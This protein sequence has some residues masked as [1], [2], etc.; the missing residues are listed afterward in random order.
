MKWIPLALLGVAA[1]AADINWTTYGGNA[2][3]WRYSELAQITGANVN[4]LVPK[5]IFQTGIAGKAESSPLIYD[6]MMYVTAPSNHAYAVDLRTG[7]AVWTYSKTP[8]KA[9]DLCCQEVNRGLAVFGDRL[10]KV[11]IEDT[12]VALD[13]ATGKMIWEKVIGDY[14][15]GYSGTLA[16]LIVKDKVLVGTAGAEFGTRGFVDAYSAASGERLW[17]FYT[18]PEA[19]AAGA[20]TWGK[21]ETLRV[22]GSTWITGTYDSELNLV[23][24][25]TGNP[26]PDMNGDVRPGDNLYT[27]SLVAIDADTG[28]AKWHFQF[29]PHD[30]HD[31]DAV[32]DPVL[33]D[34]TMGG[35]KVKAVIQ[36]NRNGYFYALDRTN[37]KFLLARPY[38]EINW[39][40]GIDAD[41]R[42]ITI[43][44]LDPSN[45]GT[46]VCPGMGGGHNW[47][48]TAYSP[49]T[50]LYYFGSADGCHNFYRHDSEFVEGEWYQLSGAREPA[51]ERSQG[52]FL[53][54]DPATGDIRWRFSMVRNPSGGA[55]ATAGG[56]V[57]VGDASGNLIAFD[58]RSGKV[59]W[60]FQTGAAIYA[61]PV[62]YSFEGRQYIA[63]ESSAAVVVFGLP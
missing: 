48:A 26:G 15:K 33:V 6:G 22:G 42:P 39:S 24:W 21:D 18:V 59:L 2:A 30:T 27:C 52:S 38:T 41:G 9:L 54:V 62:S 35:N 47:Q 32:A 45:Q 1:G 4:S 3:G 31:W 56:L 55:L 25:G 16:P 11:N 36:A 40:T 5:W 17:R 46:R 13:R 61:P 49:Q 29:T 23:Y 44:G 60:R 51:G 19:K 53:A 14:K 7:H 43:A 10:F 28:K 34:L 57:F 50:G 20:E 37:G 63:L 58:A 8:P 12:L